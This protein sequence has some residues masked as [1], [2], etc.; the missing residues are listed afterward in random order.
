[1][2]SNGNKKHGTIKKSQ[3][4]MR[5][6]AERRWEANAK[7]RAERER[8]RKLADSRKRARV[9]VLRAKGAVARLERR[10]KELGENSQLRARL[11]QSKV[12]ASARMVAANV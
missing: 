12:K 10:I 4:Q 2:A 1:M 5:Y 11:M 9:V 3:A 8:K 6:T 7:L